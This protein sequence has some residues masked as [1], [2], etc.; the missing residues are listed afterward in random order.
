MK[1]FLSACLLFAWMI[2][3]DNVTVDTQ[4][5]V[6]FTVR[7]SAGAVRRNATASFPLSMSDE[8][9]IVQLRA[10]VD[11][12]MNPPKARTLSSGMQIRSDDVQ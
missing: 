9:I 5:H 6:T 2:T 1:H 4:K 11:A 3:I 8:Q 12:Q 10:Q 7:D